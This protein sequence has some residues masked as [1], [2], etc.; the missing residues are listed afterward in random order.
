MSI[1]RAVFL[2][3]GTAVNIVLKADQGSGRLTTGKIKDLLTR[4]DH[5]RG[6][7]VRLEDGQIGRVQSLANGSSLVAP[8]NVPNQSSS[9]SLHEFKFQED[10]RNQPQPP[11]AI[12]RSLEDYIKIKPTKKGKP[13]KAQAEDV[14]GCS[15]SSHGEVLQRSLEKEFPSMDSS[16]IAAILSDSDDANGARSILQALTKS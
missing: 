9:K 11:P 4:G 3:P 6:I 14:S 7:K 16:L 2:G 8:E 13:I 15:G 10:I 12:E 5:P 1:P